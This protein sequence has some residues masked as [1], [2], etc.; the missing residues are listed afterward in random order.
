MKKEKKETQVTETR[1]FY[2]AVDGTKF[3]YNDCD[4]EEEA[5]EQCFQYERS[6]RCAILNRLGDRFE[7]VNSHK[8]IYKSASL[9]YLNDDAEAWTFSPKSEEDIRSLMIYVS[10]LDGGWVKCSERELSNLKVN[11]KYIFFKEYDSGF[12]AIASKEIFD[13]QLKSA[14]EEFNNLFEDETSVNETSVNETS[15]DEKDN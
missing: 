15:V 12:C 8:E 1:Y 2:E 11:E 9:F 10:S 3:Y 7:K 14:K 13:K 6:L 5:H 4:S